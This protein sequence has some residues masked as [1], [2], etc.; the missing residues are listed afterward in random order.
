MDWLKWFVTDML[1]RFQ[2]YM[3]VPC[4]LAYGLLPLMTFFFFCRFC[5]VSF[6]WLLGV[7]YLLLSACLYAWEIP[8]HLQGSPGL[9]LEILLLTGCGCVLLKQKKTEALTMS[10]LILSV[11]SVSNGIMSWIGYRI[12][13]P[14]LLKHEMW[15][16]PSDTVRECLRL[17]LVCGLF[18]FI[19]NHFRQSILTTSRQTLIQL[20]IPVFF[21]SMVVRIIQTS[22]YGTEI[23][24]DSGTGEALPTLNIN[25]TELLFLQLF[26][27]AC[28]LVTL[29]A[30][31]RIVHILQAEQKVQL[32]ERQTAEQEIYMQEAVLRDRQTRAFRHDI[33]NHLTV[34]S[35]LLKAG[36]TDRAYEYLSNLEQAAAEL[37]CSVRTGNPA[38]DALLGSKFS[39]AEQEGIRIQC[40]LAIPEQSPMKDMDWCILLSNAVD[41]AIK[42]CKEVPQEDRLIHITSREKG[43]FYLLAVENSCIRELKQVPED[44]VGLSNIRTVAE[45]N[46]GIAQNTVSDGTYRLRILFNDLQQ[47]SL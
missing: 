12:M 30:Y 38:V 15:L 29:S 13:L 39:M 6:R 37:S 14:Y 40:E 4:L 26:A 42:A 31:Q 19:L 47:K 9:L 44:G 7:C 2:W 36:Q 45:K 35:E 32:L 28:L 46:H 25:H 33:K 21:I 41:N 43:K 34:L 24:V 18:V 8:Y 10:V 16:L 20:T 5:R 17:L 22:F 27:C 1:P 3:V 11:L 23:R